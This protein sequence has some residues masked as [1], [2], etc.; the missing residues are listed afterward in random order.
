[1]L[2]LIMALSRGRSGTP[3][4]SRNPWTPNLG[5]WNPSI[6]LRGKATSMRRI[7]PEAEML[8]NRTVISADMLVEKLCAG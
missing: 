3:S 2:G 8:P 5:P 1:M 4:T 7:M 6:I